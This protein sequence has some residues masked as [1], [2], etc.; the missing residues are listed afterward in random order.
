MS[1]DVL[2]T[3]FLILKGLVILALSIYAVFAFV[4]VRQERLMA[5]VLEETF[6]PLL[7]LLT[8]VHFALSLGLILLAVVVI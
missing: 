8:F 3:A 6:E 5:T 1:P 2:P 7:R 4:M